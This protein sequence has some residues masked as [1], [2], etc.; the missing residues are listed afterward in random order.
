MVKHLTLYKSRRKLSTVRKK[1]INLAARVISRRRRYEH[2][3][4]VI[5]QLGWLDVHQMTDY[6]D[7]ISRYIPVIL[8]AFPFL[9]SPTLRLTFLMDGLVIFPAGLETF[10]KQTKY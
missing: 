8:L 2:I 9:A 1:N 7:L 5:S 4:D 6:V 3:S 10:L